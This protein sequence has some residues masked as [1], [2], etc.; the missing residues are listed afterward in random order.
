MQR[1][2]FCS[3]GYNGHFVVVT[4]IGGDHLTIHDGLIKGTRTLCLARG[5]DVLELDVAVPTR[6]SHKF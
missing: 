2:F 4:G 3:K 6:L 5:V 1:Q